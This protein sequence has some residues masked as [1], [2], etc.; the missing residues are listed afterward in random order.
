MFKIKSNKTETTVSYV[1]V[2]LY[3]FQINFTASLLGGTHLSIGFCIA[4][5]EI[6]L[7]ITKWDKLLPI[8]FYLFNT[9]GK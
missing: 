8:I 6:S 4:M 5:F 7:T 2:F 1:F 3:L 9:G